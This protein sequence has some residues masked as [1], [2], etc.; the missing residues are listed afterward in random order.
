MLIL[1]VAS[2]KLS[3][4][5]TARSS[6]SR[7]SSSR[8]VLKCRYDVV[9]AARILLI[10]VVSPGSCSGAGRFRYSNIGIPAASRYSSS[11]PE[12]SIPGPTQPYRCQ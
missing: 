8:A 10:I 12:I 7:R 11:R 6:T 4:S 5:N 9:P 1:I 3:L 2:A